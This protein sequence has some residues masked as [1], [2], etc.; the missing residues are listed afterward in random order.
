MCHPIV[1]FKVV[2][3]IIAHHNHHHQQQHGTFDVEQFKLLPCISSKKNMKRKKEKKRN[4]FHRVK[5][6]SL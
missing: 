5:R 6:W 4:Q 2:I 1:K 3:I